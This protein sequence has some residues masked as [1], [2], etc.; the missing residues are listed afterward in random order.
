MRTCDNGPVHIHPTHAQYA[1]NATKPSKLQA[2]SVMKTRA[3]KKHA[4]ADDISEDART[5]G[6]K[7]MQE[8]MP[9]DVMAHF[10]P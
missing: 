3:A 5:Y 7:L 6:W 10:T 1:H 2:S 4:S 9:T 8:I